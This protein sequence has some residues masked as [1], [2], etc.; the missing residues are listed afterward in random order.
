[1]SHLARLLFAALLA[2]ASPALA[3]PPPPVPALPDSP[4]LTTYSVA[5][6]TCICAVNFALFGDSTDI[7]SWLEVWVA[8][9][10][11]LSSDAS[12]GWGLTSAT[13]PLAT[14]PR[15]ITDAVLTFTATQTGTVQI[16]GARRPRRTSQFQENRGVA[17]RD[18]N[19]IITDEV[20]MLRENW[21]KTNDLTG[22]GLFFAPGNT[23]GP[24]PSATACKSGFLAFDS[25][26]LNPICQAL[27]PTGSVSVPVSTTVGHFA[28]WGN[29]TGTM[30][31]DYN[32][33]AGN[34]TFTGNNSF[35]TGTNTFTMP[36][37]GA[38]V[39]QNF[40]AIIQRLNDRVLI[41]GAAANDG[42]YPNVTKDWLET[43]IGNTTQVSQQATLSTIGYGYAGT[44][45]I[46]TSDGSA[47]S[48]ATNAFAVGSFAVN[49]ST[50]A[51]GGPRTTW[52]NYGETRLTSTAAAGAIAQGSEQ[53]VINMTGGTV[54]SV[55]PYD[56]VTNLTTTGFWAASG[57]PAVS[58]IDA[59]V[60]YAVKNNGSA[61]SSGLV[62]EKNSLTGDD[63]TTGTAHAIELAKGHQIEWYVSGTT[64]PAAY[65]RSDMTSAST[66]Q[67]LIATNSGFTVSAIGPATNAW[68]TTAPTVA[69][70][71]CST[72][73]PVTALSANNGT[74]AFDILIGA[75]T[76]GSTGTLTMPAATT[77]WVC[78]ATDVTTPAG[79][80][81]VQTG[82]N[83]STT[84]VVLTDYSRTAGTAQNFLAA[85][86]IHVM[87]TGY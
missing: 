20:A 29:T 34:N 55:Y 50:A 43:L 4:R 33:L 62:F 48:G 70:G 84:A 37:H 41:G 24:M 73:S 32:L 87:C 86:H 79:H 56:L 38:V 25:T 35:T 7:D 21:D 71:F 19:Q 77:G 30:L 44:F 2:L 60:A 46:R 42:V 78:S 80:N 10:R 58:T 81:V 6:T 83:G 63:G 74:A 22:R 12:H 28:T 39:Y 76:C 75:A 9:V 23:T 66:P 18:L 82:T 47:V 54:G 85:D 11:Y 67:T 49:D 16:V 52:S 72:G 69:S 17:A 45:G 15:P 65:L 51:P 57:K 68:L 59:T 8:G 26:G 5:G 1:M 64:T 61:F 36:S 31:L 3:A 40:S 53:D 13:G 14:I 27:V